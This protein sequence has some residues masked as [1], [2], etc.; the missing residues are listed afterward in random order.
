MHT[1]VCPLRY[2]CTHTY[3]ARTHAHTPKLIYT[4]PPKFTIDNRLGEVS[5]VYILHILTFDLPD[6]IFLNCP[7]QFSLLAPR[8]STPCRAYYNCQKHSTVY[9]T[10]CWL[11]TYSSSI[12]E[13][14]SRCVLLKFSLTSGDNSMVRLS[15][16]L[17]NEAIMILVTCTLVCTGS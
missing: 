10:S 11:D 7:E 15:F 12:I 5:M 14:G 16:S 8:V 3:A 13:G 2:R 9:Y 17:E 1:N 4:L 6:W